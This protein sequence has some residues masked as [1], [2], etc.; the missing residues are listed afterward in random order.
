[1]FIIC[2]IMN[3]KKINFKGE[4]LWKTILLNLKTE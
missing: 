2:L 4:I 3:L 1:M